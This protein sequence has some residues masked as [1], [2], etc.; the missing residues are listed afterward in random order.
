MKKIK[1]LICDD[2]QMMLDG[3]KL[4]LSNIENII[5]VG[6]AHNGEETIEWLGNNETDIILMD[7]NMPVMDGLKACKILNK[8]YDNIK[9]IFLSMIN[10][11]SI[12]HSL[13]ESGAKGYLLK[14]SG[15]EELSI[16]IQNV[17]DGG[18]F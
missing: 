8:K 6:Q 18:V 2:H 5:V 11:S 3:I 15:Q 14:N 16:A 10:Q 17:Y 7:I 1:V 4:I 12:I 13:I 9:V